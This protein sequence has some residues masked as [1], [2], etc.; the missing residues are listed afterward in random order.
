MSPRN[1]QLPL[2]DFSWP[3]DGR[4]I[5]QYNRRTTLVCS[6]GLM[7]FYGFVVGDSMPYKGVTVVA[8]TFREIMIDLFAQAFD[9]TCC[10]PGEDPPYEL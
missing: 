8:E 10:Q 5:I 1:N 4:I 9:A 7:Q 2:N 6:R 3:V